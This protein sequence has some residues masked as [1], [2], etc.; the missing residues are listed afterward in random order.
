MYPEIYKQCMYN[1]FLL[2]Q[3]VDQIVVFILNF[4]EIRLY[5]TAVYA[6]FISL[7]QVVLN[8]SYVFSHIKIYMRV[9]VYRQ[10]MYFFYI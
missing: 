6:N 5:H 7:C 8:E 9:V 3:K 2:K 4:K 1:W 10:R